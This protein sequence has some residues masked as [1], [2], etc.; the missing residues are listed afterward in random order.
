MF[1]LFL[2]SLC[3][4]KCDGSGLSQN[5]FNCSRVAQ[6]ALVLGPVS[7]YSLP[8]STSKGSGD[9]TF[10]WSR[11]Q[12]P[13]QSESVYLAPRASAIQKQGFIDEVAERIEAPQRLS[14]RAVYKSK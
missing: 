4:T 5:D 1:M 11:S 12:E 7:L 14:T 2:Q 3:S 13:Q 8:T 10:Q 9:T 6:H